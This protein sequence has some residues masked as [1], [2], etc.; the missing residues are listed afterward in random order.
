MQSGF[1]SGLQR[2]IPAFI[3]HGNCRDTHLCNCKL[4]SFLAIRISYLA[5]SCSSSAEGFPL[6]LRTASPGLRL[7][8][9]AKL[10]GFTWGERRVVS[11]LVYRGLPGER[12]EWSVG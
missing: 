4:R 10:P 11:W 3:Y 1:A 12:E 6:I 8:C 2:T 9:S 5:F 7:Y